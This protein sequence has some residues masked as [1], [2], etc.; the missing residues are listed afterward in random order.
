MI[1]AGLALIFVPARAVLQ[2][3]SPGDVR[4]RV[5]ATQLFMN[6]VVSTLPLPVIGG[7]ADRVGFGPV[8]ICLALL[9]LG[10][11]ATGLWHARKE[12]RA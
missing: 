8:M 3:Q 10:V 5:I 7:L 4:G 12:C 1:G 11:G 6:N 2:K 9:S